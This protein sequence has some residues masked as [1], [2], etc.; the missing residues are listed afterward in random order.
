[1]IRFILAWFGYVKVPK[2]AIQLSMM[3]EDGWRVVLKH[4]P[5]NIES[6]PKLLKINQTLTK[7]LRSGR[8]LQ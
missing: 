5:D 3:L 7:F 2:E 6:A 4:I 8:L 1:M